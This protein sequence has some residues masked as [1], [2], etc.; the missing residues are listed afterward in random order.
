MSDE[1]LEAV[2]IDAVAKVRELQQIA[3]AYNDY[4]GVLGVREEVEE[5]VDTLIRDL[6][7]AR[8]LARRLGLR[9]QKWEAGERNVDLLSSAA[10]PP[11]APPRTP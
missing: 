1:T 10:V 6:R 11:V 4:G 3:H 2:A 7:R 9:V 5:I 8:R